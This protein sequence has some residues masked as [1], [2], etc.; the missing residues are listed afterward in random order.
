MIAEE[1]IKSQYNK[2]LAFNYGDKESLIKQ[3]SKAL[4]LYKRSKNQSH[5]K[6][7]HRIELYAKIIEYA[8][9]DK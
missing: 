4:V 6:T 3:V 2:T 1:T 7:K 9:H 8:K 5:N